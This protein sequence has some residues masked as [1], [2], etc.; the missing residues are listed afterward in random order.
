MISLVRN[1]L[2]LQ[3]YFKKI[4]IININNVKKLSYIRSVLLKKKETL[5]EKNKN[6]NI[7]IPNQYSRHT[8]P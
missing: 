1:V 4:I 2:D 5:I 7:V 8:D 3:N 6:V